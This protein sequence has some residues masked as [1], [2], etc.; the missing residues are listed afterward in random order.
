MCHTQNIQ[1]SI[2]NYNVSNS[3]I[4]WTQEYQRKQKLICKWL[5]YLPAYKMR[6]FLYTS[7]ENLGHLIVRHKVKHIMYKHFPRIEGCNWAASYFQVNTVFLFPFYMHFSGMNFVMWHTSPMQFHSCHVISN[8]SYFHLNLWHFTSHL[9]RHNSCI[10]SSNPPNIHLGHQTYRYSS[11]EFVVCIQKHRS[12][13][14]HSPKEEITK[15]TMS[16][17]ARQ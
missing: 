3:N 13:R 1:Y 16:I 8:I 9:Q 6:N 2:N 4:Y 7:Y 17:T 11:G 5:P 14:T 10:W 12:D 15:T